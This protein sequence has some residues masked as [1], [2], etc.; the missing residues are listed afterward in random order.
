MANGRKPTILIEGKS[1]REISERYGIREGTLRARYHPGI[2]LRELVCK[3]KQGM[4]PKG[5]RVV[6]DMTLSEIAAESGLHY[7]TIYWRY[8]HGFTT[9]AEL[10]AGLHALRKTKKKKGDKT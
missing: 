1:L 9:Y 10:T 5:F 2:T 4:M 7:N 3:T 6:G 8:R